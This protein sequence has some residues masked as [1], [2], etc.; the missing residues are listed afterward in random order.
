MAT[1][2]VNPRTNRI[3]QRKH[4]PK[5]FTIAENG[6]DLV[7]TTNAFDNDLLFINN[8]YYYP[9]K[10]YFNIHKIED[11]L[12]DSKLWHDTIEEDMESPIDTIKHKD[13][14]DIMEASNVRVIFNPLTCTLAS[15]TILLDISVLRSFSF[16]HKRLM[17]VRTMN[18]SIHNGVYYNNKIILEKNIQAN[19]VMY[20]KMEVFSNDCANVIGSFLNISERYMFNKVIKGKQ[21]V[22]LT[23]LSKAIDTNDTALH[24]M[25]GR[26]HNRDFI[27][28]WFRELPILNQ[29]WTH[30]TAI[31]DTNSY[32]HQ[33]YLSLYTNMIR[34][35]SYPVLCDIVFS[36]DVMI[37]F[38][39]FV[40]LTP[41]TSTQLYNTCILHKVNPITM[42]E[43]YH[44]LIEMLE[45]NYVDKTQFLVDM[46]D[47]AVQYDT[48]TLEFI[49]KYIL[50][51]NDILDRSILYYNVYMKIITTTN[52]R[53]DTYSMHRFNTTLALNGILMIV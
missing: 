1:H 10:K 52:K 4:I 21:S 13:L 17:P 46:T 6:L 49:L 19:D 3:V 35:L 2:Y 18:Y 25:I 15:C 37:N 40:H 50:D 42:I 51:H 30:H 26:L 33:D 22:D 14:F 24:N 38:Y 16:I 39:K 11:V 41:E 36:N 12:V 8:R 29:P 27:E 47:G 7:P 20:S 28:Y 5:G 32:S 44:R 48:N 34:S 53:I 23:E 31:V 45:A 9:D 43:H